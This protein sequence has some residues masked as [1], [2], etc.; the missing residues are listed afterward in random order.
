MRDFLLINPE[1]VA[2]NPDGVL[3]ALNDAILAHGGSQS[4]DSPTSSQAAFFDIKEETN[5]LYAQA[6]FEHGIFRGN[7][8][9]RYIETE[10]TSTGNTITNG[11][12]TPTSTSGS[13]D[14]ILPRFNLVAN[15]ADDVVL[16]FGYS[17]DIRRPD[18]DDLTTSI[19]YSTSP[20]PAVSIGNPGLKPQEVESFD[21]SAEWYF[22]PSAVIS[23][24]YFHKTRTGLFVAQQEDPV[25]TPATLSDGSP[26]LVRD[27]TAPCE[28]GG[29]FNPIADWNVFAPLDASGNRLQGV[30]ICV[31]SAQIINGEGENTQKGYEIAFQYDLSEFEDRL[32]WASGFGLI[33][34]F[35]HQEFEGG[36]EYWTP[37]S[38]AATVFESLGSTDVKLRVTE[39]DLSENAYNATLYYEKY[40]LSARARY[41]WRDAYRSTDFGSTSSFPWGFPVV[42][43]ARGQLNGSVTYDVTDKLSIGIEGVNLTES[44]VEQSCVNE[45]GLLCFQGLTD[46]RITFGATYN[47]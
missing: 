8:G 13:Y 26:T 14:F 9:L 38:R 17:K 30:G 34:N 19:T 1:L 46:R 44:N 12:A 25:E 11:V 27:V 47:F 36:E 15:P 5:A 7:A 18:F 37:T 3:A 32:G 29:V 22:A 10:V 24:G 4:I 33:A 39:I 28:G 23:I 6:N 20:N 40:G 16:R 2:S 45:G 42:Q 31:P 21:V 43:E 35:T 41:T